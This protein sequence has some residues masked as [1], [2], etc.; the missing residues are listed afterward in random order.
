MSLKYLVCVPVLTFGLCVANTSTAQ[1]KG[2]TFYQDIEPILANNCA[3]CHQPGKSAPFSLLT[4]EDVS[5]RGEFIANVTASRYMPPWKADV[6]F[7]SYK[8]ERALSDQEIKLIGD[9]VTAGMPKGKKKKGQSTVTT[10]GVNHAPDLSIKMPSPYI[11]TSEGKDDYRFFNIPTNLPEDKFITRIE[12]IPGNARLVHHSRLMTDT[13]H[14]VRA[15]NGLSANDP[16]IGEFEKYPPLDKFLYGWVPGNFPISFPAGTGKKLHKDTDIILNI[17]YS[18]NRR[19]NQIDQSTINFYFARGPVDREVY[20]LAIAEESI[21][22]PPFEIRANEKK[23]FYSSF[24]PI[25]VDISA[26][27]V[28][29]HMH[30]LGKTFKAFAITP[31]DS[32]IHL[33]K[34]DSWDFKWQDTYQFSQLL[35]IPKGSVIIMEATFDNTSS[36]PS[37]P[38]IPPKDVTYGWN[39]SSEMMDL[40]LYYML[41]RAGDEQIDQ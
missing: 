3:S 4:Y 11:I 10:I 28:L 34:I 40:V 22:N 29:P 25:P 31:N 5:K 8:N 37:N 39:S 23:T 17:H 33:I 32:A 15:I 41:Y 27:G 20:S 26:I 13:S 19:S 12:F 7:Q 2:P 35:Q 9:W 30:Y 16:D 38:S 21:S 36:N 1:K 24:G 6:A 14:K 18:P